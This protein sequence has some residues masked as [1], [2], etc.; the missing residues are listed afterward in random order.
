MKKKVYYNHDNQNGLQDT[1]DQKALAVR[2]DLDDWYVEAKFNEPTF[3]FSENTYCGFIHHKIHEIWDGL[4][5]STGGLE[6]FDTYE[7]TILLHKGLNEA[8]T[9]LDVYIQKMDL[10]QF[11]DVLWACNDETEY[12]IIID[13]EEFRDGLK[14]LSSF[15][16]ESANIPKKSIEFWL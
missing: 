1:F 13:N 5:I 7:E 10:K 14:R 8:K 9:R 11:S 3:L 15:I 2:I 6:P 12:R 16:S 4:P